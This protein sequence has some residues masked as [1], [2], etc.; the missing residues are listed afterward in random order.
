MYTVGYMDTEY[1]FLQLNGEDLAS[2]DPVLRTPIGL[3]G[4]IEM[5][6]AILNAKP[7]N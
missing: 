7:M 5:E 3:T 4:I 1:S 6:C 2:A